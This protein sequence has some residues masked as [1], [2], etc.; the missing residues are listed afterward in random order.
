MNKFFEP[1]M[2]IDR[3]QDPNIVAPNERS[4]CEKGTYNVEAQS[5]LA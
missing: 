1:R 5:S 3:S 2:D 4:Y